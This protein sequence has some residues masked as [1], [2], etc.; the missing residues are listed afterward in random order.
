MIFKSFFAAAAISAL[1]AQALA[2]EPINLDAGLAVLSE[3]VD[4]PGFSGVVILSRGDEILFSEVRGEADQSAGRANSAETR[5]NIAS[6]G[7]FITA[8]ALIEAGERHGLSP[9]EIHPAEWFPDHP[10]LFAPDLTADL[11]LAHATTTQ[12]FLRD[13][14]ATLQAM[15]DARSNHDVFELTVAAQTAPITRNPNGLAYSNAALILA[16]ELIERMTGQSYEDFVREAVFAPAGVD[17]SFTRTAE[18]G[19]RGLALGYLPEGFEMSHEPPMLEPGDPLPTEYTQLADSSLGDMISSAA[20]GLYATGLELS[21]IGQAALAD[22]IVEPDAL[23]WMCTSIAPFPGPIFGRGCGGHELAGDRR[24]W[25]HNGGAPG[26]NAELALYPEENI[27]LVVL[28]NHEMRATPVLMEF[29]AVT[30]GYP[31]LPDGIVV[32]E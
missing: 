14:P 4:T 27:V 23:E 13:D 5:F 16:G 15:A 2:Q 25:G 8:M 1:S 19:A 10:D 21:A 9:E 28:S 32:L 24:R 3:A 31:D 22:D 20:G 26:V 18:A 29:E 11:L 30:F 17:P 6:I 7:K 12:S